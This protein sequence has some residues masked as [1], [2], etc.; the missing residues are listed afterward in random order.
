MFQNTEFGL[1]QDIPSILI[2][3]MSLS[4]DINDVVLSGGTAGPV[5]GAQRC[6]HIHPVRLGKYLPWHLQATLT[7]P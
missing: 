7:I 2:G 4:T 5:M 6:T 3:C 1:I